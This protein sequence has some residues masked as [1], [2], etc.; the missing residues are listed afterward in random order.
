MSYNILLVDDQRD[1]L[2]VLRSALETLKDEKIKV[3]ESQSG[4]EALLEASRHKV[5]L[6]VTDYKLPGMSGVELVGRILTRHPGA[7]IIV[8]SGVTDAKSRKEM[9]NAGAMAVFEKPIPIADFL[10]A[11]ERGLG[12]VKTIFAPETALSEKPEQPRVKLSDLLADF[13][14]SVNAE[15][16]L[17]LNDA[18]QVH[19]RAGSLRDESVETALASVLISIHGASLKVARYTRQ[20]NILPYH[21]FSGGGYDMLFAPLSPSFGLLAAGGNLASK[22]RLLESVEKM[23]ALR[24]EVEK[25][26]SAIGSVEDVATEVKKAAPRGVS[27]A[28][29]VP[30]IRLSK[31]VEVPPAPE[32]EALLKSAAEKK[33]AVTDVD[34]FWNQ[35]AEKLANKPTDPNVISLEEAR[36]MGLIPDDKI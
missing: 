27:A 33:P 14:Q 3:F 13:R 18:G 34:D 2:R 12:L 4:E 23:L 24:S 31:P 30:T 7:K 32:M 26:L 16:V 28:T 20:E 22:E 5:D 15:A 11:V 6:L 25:A 21:V 17:M 36:K 19:A 8:I 9:N 10:D 35:A 1:I 29:A